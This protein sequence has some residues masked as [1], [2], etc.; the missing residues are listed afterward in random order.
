MSNTINIELG[1]EIGQ[2]FTYNEYSWKT[3]QDNHFK[4]R[5]IVIYINK[6]GIMVKYGTYVDC[7]RYNK[8]K[9]FWHQSTKYFTED[10]LSKVLERK[11][12]N[13]MR[14]LKF[15]IGDIAINGVNRQVP[16]D[17]ATY[18]GS[19][20]FVGNVFEVNEIRIIIGADNKNDV[21]ISSNNILYDGFEGRIIK[22]DGKQYHGHQ[23]SEKYSGLI[24][25][26]DIDGLIDIICKEMSKKAWLNDYRALYD[27]ETL[28]PII[29]YECYQNPFAGLF[30]YLGV[31]ERAKHTFKKYLDE[32]TNGTIRVK[33]T[34]KGEVDKEKLNNIINSL[35]NKEREA[36]LKALKNNK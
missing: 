3:D 20:I 16:D 11:P 14:N 19:N 21:I 17:I 27:V 8:E 15:E 35:S 23:C 22:N 2:E 9:T 4:I 10:E 5:N 24:S 13:Y 33:K 1:F 6:S 12:H 29:K 28:E 32:R 7:S 31:E 18:K 36:M 26:F 25:S 30:K 34:K